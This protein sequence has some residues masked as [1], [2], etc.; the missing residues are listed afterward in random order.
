MALKPWTPS[1][2]IGVPAVMVPEVLTLSTTT[3]AE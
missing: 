2:L 3:T 1:T